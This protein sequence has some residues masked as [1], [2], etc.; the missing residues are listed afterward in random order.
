MAYAVE[1]LSSLP[2]KPAAFDDPA[3]ERL[4]D[5]ELMRR[6][7]S[8]DRDAFAVVYDLHSRAALAFSLRIARVREVAEEAVQETFVRLWLSADRYQPERGSLRNFVLGIARH[9]ALDILRRD[10][11]RTRRR[12]SDELLESEPDGSPRPDLQVVMRD[13][14]EVL[15]A[16]VDGLSAV[17]S[18]AVE[19]AY[20]GG[21][22]HSEIAARLDIPLGTVKSRIRIGLANLRGELLQPVL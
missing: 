21:L 19:L 7:A 10:A 14:A 6:V 20:F 3:G 13:E 16:A 9:R 15:R 11:L 12:V 4:R 1:Q 18:E 17:Q 22:S 5:A 8:G 2:T